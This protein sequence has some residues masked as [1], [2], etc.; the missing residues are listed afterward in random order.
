MEEI[1]QSFLITLSPGFSKLEL[2]VENVNYEFQRILSINRAV[3]DF[4]MGCYDEDTFLD[5]VES[6][7]Q[8][9]DEYVE[10]VNDNLAYIVYG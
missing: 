2:E 10:I 1:E 7:N 4:L 5:I 9:M 8:D 6:H 3:E